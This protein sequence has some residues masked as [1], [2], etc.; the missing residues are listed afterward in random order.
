MKTY[1]R[2]L[3][4][5]WN[6]RAQAWQLANRRQIT[7]EVPQTFRNHLLG[8]IRE[9]LTTADFSTRRKPSG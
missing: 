1:W 5:W 8:A 6:Y 4:L 3:S 9:A 2:F 7:V